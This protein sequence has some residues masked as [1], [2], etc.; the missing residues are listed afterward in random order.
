MNF[1]K[2]SKYWLFSLGILVV[3]GWS[4][5]RDTIRDE[6]QGLSD[7]ASFTADISVKDVALTRNSHA[8]EVFRLTS[9]SATLLEMG[10]KMELDQIT[11]DIN[12]EAGKT[13][14]VTAPEGRYEMDKKLELTG[15]V[16]VT[17]PDDKKLFT[18]RLEYDQQGKMVFSPTPV[19]LVAKD[20]LLTGDRFE[21]NLESGNLRITN[22][23][24]TL[25]QAGNLF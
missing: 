4:V 13:W 24:G 16:V 7:L 25:F 23:R 2:Q 14:K 5:F 1:W 12:T 17:F 21:Y 9:Q 6:K 20:L 11:F 19:K 10:K 3:V 15:D 8:G 22:Q 18:S